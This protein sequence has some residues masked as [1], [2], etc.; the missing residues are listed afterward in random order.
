MALILNTFKCSI[1]HGVIKPS[2]IWHSINAVDQFLDVPESCVLTNEDAS[3]QRICPLC[4]QERAHT[5]TTRFNGFT[6]NMPPKLIIL[7]C[8]KNF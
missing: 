6:I 7:A 3:R 8:N 4:Q 2:A 1:C 5:E